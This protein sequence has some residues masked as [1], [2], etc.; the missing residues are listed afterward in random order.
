MPAPPPIPRMADISPMLPATRSRGNSSRMI[1]KA[2]GKMPP[3]APCTTRPAISSGSDVANAEISVPA[4]RT[5]STPTSTRSLPWMSPRRPSSGV[6]T[7][8]LSR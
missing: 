4:P 2:S 1:P 6:A 5:T 3:P 7:E 8:A